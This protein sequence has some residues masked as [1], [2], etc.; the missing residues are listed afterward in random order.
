MERRLYNEHFDVLRSG[1]V[2]QGSGVV[3]TKYDLP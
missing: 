3:P 2:G 1:I